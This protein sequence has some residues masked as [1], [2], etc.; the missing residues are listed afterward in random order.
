MGLMNKKGSMP[1]DLILVMITLFIFAV[2]LLVAYTVWDEY[3]Q[4][5]NTTLTSSV[6]EHINNKTDVMLSAF[7]YLFMFMV[8][9]LVIALVI[10][11]MLIKSHPA[12][13]WI[14]LFLL[15]IIIIIAGVFSN[16]YS[17]ISNTTSFSRADNEYD[18][19]KFVMDRFPTFILF[20]SVIVL[21]VLYARSR[22]SGG[23]GY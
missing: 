23:G 3:K 4:G 19:V 17:E 21:I 10:S 15:V 1:M 5:T 16:A 7:D 11:V 12:F 2:S 18:T 9:G 14:T 6:Q 8:V 13:F 22:Y 20:M